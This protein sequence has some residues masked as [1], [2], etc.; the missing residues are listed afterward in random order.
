MLKRK[1]NVSGI[2]SRLLRPVLHITDSRNIPFRCV[3]TSILFFKSVDL[4]HIFNTISLVATNS[5]HVVNKN[6]IFISVVVQ[7]VHYILD[8]RCVVL[9]SGSHVCKFGDVIPQCFR[10][11]FMGILFGIISCLSKQNE[12]D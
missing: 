11:I 1:L 9:H 6:M 5:Q 7:H 12:V 8:C 2:I 3:F 4:Q 10:Y